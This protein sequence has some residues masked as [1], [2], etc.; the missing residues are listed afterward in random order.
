MKTVALIFAG[1]M[2][3][4]MTSSSCPK[5]FMVIKGKPVIVHTLEKFAKSPFVDAIVVVCLS[6]YV[7][8]LKN[9]IE[10]YRVN[11]VLS[12]IEGGRTGQESIF[13][14]LSEIRRLAEGNPIVLIHDGVRPFISNETISENV[15]CAKKNGNA[16]TVAQ[17]IETIAV[18]EEGQT[19]S[20]V[21]ERSKCV[22]AKAPQTFYLQDILEVHKQAQEEGITDAVDSSSLMFKYGKKL[23]TVKCSGANIKITTPEDFYFARALFDIE[24]DKQLKK[25]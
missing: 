15:K 7:G 22:L 4:R 11:K 18:M 14:G 2:G 5:Q 6:N 8:Y 24:E 19:I 3:K 1:G 10:E 13:N 20:E 21:Y 12:V 9:I 25:L 17:A 23:F 16:I